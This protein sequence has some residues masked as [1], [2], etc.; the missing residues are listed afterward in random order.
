M[1]A[2]GTAKDCVALSWLSFDAESFRKASQLF[3]PAECARPWQLLVQD[4]PHSRTYYEG[5][6]V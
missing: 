6:Y 1:W 3:L 4:G 5:L 2:L